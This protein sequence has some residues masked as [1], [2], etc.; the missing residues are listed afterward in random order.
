MARKCGRVVPAP[1]KKRVQVRYLF[2][3]VLGTIVLIVVSTILLII[4]PRQANS[5]SFLCIFLFRQALGHKPVHSIRKDFI[6]YAYFYHT[7]FDLQF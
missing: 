7:F 5:T 3:E 2:V 1:Y 4:V 6:A